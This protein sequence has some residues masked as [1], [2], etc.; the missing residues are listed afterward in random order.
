MPH[1]SF[2]LFVHIASSPSTSHPTFLCP[3]VPLLSC[4]AGTIKPSP[5]AHTK[6]AILLY[7]V[8]SGRVNALRRCTPNDRDYNWSSQQD[9]NICE[10]MARP[11]VLPDSFNGTGETSW[12]QWIIHFDNVAAVNNW[13]DA[14][15]LKWLKIRLTGRAQTAFQR[16]SAANQSEFKKAK[17]ALEARF[18]PPSRKHRYQAELQVRRKRKTESWADFADDLRK[19]ADKAYPDLQ[20]E[21]RERLALNGYLAQLDQPQVAFGVK[22]KNPESLDAAVTATLEMEVYATPAKTGVHSVSSVESV[23]EDGG[24]TVGAVSTEDKLVALV[25][26]LV[27]CVE[28]LE[29]GQKERPPWRSGQKRAGPS[30]RS[31]TEVEW[32]EIV[33]WRCQQK[34]HIAR[35]CRA[36]VPTQAQQQQRPQSGNGRPPA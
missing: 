30:T 1:S 10:D 34:G 35:N 5:T 11:H 29:S 32:E 12:E 7:Q 4:R 20:E 2:S 6:K 26:K 3:R 17:D 27:K 25:E 33:C 28:R 8:L 18:E 16:L 24:A 36:R 15:K 31:K 9:R 21:A 13:S 23:P 14:D 19:L 22:H